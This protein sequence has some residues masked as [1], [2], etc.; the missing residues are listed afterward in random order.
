MISSIVPVFIKSATTRVDNWFGV[1]PDL[2]DPVMDSWS[3]NFGAAV[4]C[5][6]TRNPGAMI[7]E[8]VALEMVFPYFVAP[9]LSNWFN[10]GNGLNRYSRETRIHHR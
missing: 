1:P 10:R 8:N 2:F 4:S 7:L 3:T 6:P 5:H 9:A